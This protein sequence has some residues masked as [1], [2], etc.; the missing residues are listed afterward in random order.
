MNPTLVKFM[1]YGMP[2]L[3]FICSAFLPASVQLSFAASTVLGS[4]Q[5]HILR[6]RRFRDYLGI[7]PLPSTTD[8]ASKSPYKGTIT[9]QPS[10]VTAAEQPPA[11]KGIIGGAIADIKGAASQV[12]KQARELQQAGDAKRGNQRLTQAELKRA[13]AYEA[14]K[15]REI[16]QEKRDTESAPVERRRRSTG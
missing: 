3:S 13:Q 6:Q 2:L 16:A 14:Q 12:M 10:S 7:Q 15:Q 8:S 11:P 5:A 1:T 9:I 4:L